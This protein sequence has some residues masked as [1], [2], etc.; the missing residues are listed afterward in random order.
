[1]Q[2]Q[3]VVELK[4][5]KSILAKM[6]GIG[7]SIEPTFSEE[8]LNK[9]A[10]DFQKLCIQRGDWVKEDDIKKYI[11]KAPWRAGTFIRTEFKFSNYIKK[12]RE[13]YYSKNH[14]IALGKELKE[15]NV[16]LGRYMEL[17]EDK[18]NFQ[19][20]LEVLAKSKKQ[21][22]RNKPYQLPTGMKDITT[23][24][25]PNPSVDLV[26][27]DIANLKDEFH[28]NKY[29]E[30]IDIYRNGHAM[31]KHIYWF[32]K[33]LEPGLKN[34]CKKWCENFNYANEALTRMKVKKETFVLLDEK[35]MIQL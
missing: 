27:Q 25:I 5:I 15:R 11:P 16:D 6:V 13:H 14:L 9:A 35:D 17:I 18:A 1:M 3:L 8:A 28:Q 2:K 34:R 24:D 7:D 26:K 20:S 29:S 31:M 19:K 33:Y 22:G 23:S 30:Y 21:K 4:E 10:K 32:Q 12:G